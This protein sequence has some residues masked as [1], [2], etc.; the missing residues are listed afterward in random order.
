MVRHVTVK[1]T[2]IR[3]KTVFES[4]IVFFWSCVLGFISWLCIK[5][6]CNRVSPCRLIS[7]GVIIILTQYTSWWISYS[8]LFNSK[9]LIQLLLDSSFES[10]FII[11]QWIPL[12]FW[13]VSFFS[14]DTLFHGELV[15]KFETLPQSS[16]D[17][18][19]VPVFFVADD[20]LC[21]GG[22]SPLGIFLVLG[23]IVI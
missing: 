14:A 6:L 19:P 22:I 3:I 20:R 7:C 12:K 9:W 11:Q 17:G 4:R 23:L 8:L 16:F 10:V 5:P 2:W 18:F 15:L 21:F 13:R 1:H